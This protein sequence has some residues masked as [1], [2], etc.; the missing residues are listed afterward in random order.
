MRGYSTLQIVTCN[1]PGVRITRG[2][3]D[4]KTRG[5]WA[6][7]IIYTISPIGLCTAPYVAAQDCVRTNSS[8]TRQQLGAKI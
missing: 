8:L 6:L 5:Q 3:L 1:V 2:P 4:K 7:D